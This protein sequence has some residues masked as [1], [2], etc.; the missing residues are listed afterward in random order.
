MTIAHWC[1]L[2][3]GLL[4]ILVVFVSKSDPQLDIR[5]P[6]DVHIHQQGLRKRAYGAHLNGNEAFP[7][8]AVAVLSGM[9]RGAPQGSI[10]AWAFAWVILRFGY[11]AAYL[12]DWARLRS[13]LWASSV[14]VAVAIFILPLH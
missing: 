1:L 8:F 2:C 7:L 3:G 9:I 12:W 14:I 4:P 13:L 5:N 10:D 6:R 11:T